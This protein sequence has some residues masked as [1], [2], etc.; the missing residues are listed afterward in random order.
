MD[1]NLRLAVPED[2]GIAAKLIA[3]TMGGYGVMTM[4]LGSLHREEAILGDWFTRPGN[5]FSYEY[6]WLATQN[7]RIVG[8][9]LALPGNKL[10]Q[11]EKALA[12]GIFKQYSVFEVLQMLWRLMVIGRSDEADANEFVLAH[13]AVSERYRRQGVAGELI[14]KAEELAV[15][16]GFSRLVLEV[17]LDNLP[18]QALYKKTALNCNLSLN[19]AATHAPWLARVTKNL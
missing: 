15:Q 14:R 2:A 9:L 19:L 8:L 11:L 4:G 12:K 6:C 1:L 10:G 5:R 16:N 7:D 18:A 17:E 3:D 13:L